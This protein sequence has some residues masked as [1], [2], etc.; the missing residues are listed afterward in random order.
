MLLLLVVAV[1]GAKGGGGGGGYYRS[2]TL[3]NPKEVGGW[4]HIL[5]LPFPTYRIGG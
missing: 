1:L 4:H 3:V 2:R 5:R